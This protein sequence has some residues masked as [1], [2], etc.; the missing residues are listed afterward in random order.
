M[1]GFLALVYA[2]ELAGL[3][4]VSRVGRTPGR[5]EGRPRS[6]SHARFAATMT[7]QPE[8]DTP[9]INNRARSTART[10]TRFLRRIEP[11]GPRLVEAGATSR[12]CPSVS[13][14]AEPRCRLHAGPPIPTRPAPVSLPGPILAATSFAGASARTPVQ[15][16]LFGRPGGHNSE[17][18]VVLI[19]STT[20]WM[21]ATIEKWS[22]RIVL[23]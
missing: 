15:P 22:V 19:G 10:E 14:R 2:P 6:H 5:C 1:R 9:G 16:S 21:S 20:W 13:F 11:V 4:P 8:I 23:R 17:S 7:R 18:Q 3:P 12:P